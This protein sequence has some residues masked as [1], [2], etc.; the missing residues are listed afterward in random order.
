MRFLIVF[1]NIS[2]VNDAFKGSGKDPENQAGGLASDLFQME[3]PRTQSGTVPDVRRTVI[4]FTV[5]Y[6]DRGGGH[7]L[8]QC[9]NDRIS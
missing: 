7:A 5:G 2:E 9:Q 4:L 1:I 3:R 6:P 8:V